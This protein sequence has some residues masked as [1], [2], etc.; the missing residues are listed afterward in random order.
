VAAA[1]V[2]AD[3]QEAGVE[4]GAT[5]G[6]AHVAREGQVHARPTAAR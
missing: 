1:G 5:G 3:L 2:E 6:E 4:A